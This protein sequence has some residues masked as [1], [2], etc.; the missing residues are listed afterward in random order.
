[1]APQT[2]YRQVI[3]VLMD[4]QKLPEEEML[5]VHKMLD[6]FWRDSK[7]QQAFS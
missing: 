5:S 2:A 4:I 1:V 3:P 7:A 6:A